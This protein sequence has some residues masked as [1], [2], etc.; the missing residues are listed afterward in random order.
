MLGSE[1]QQLVIRSLTA[2]S[3]SAWLLSIDVRS[4][5]SPSRTRNRTKLET[6]TSIVV[7]KKETENEA[8][9]K[10]SK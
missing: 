9:P 4:G 5:L 1:S 7:K 3:P 8:V 10:E 6:F 2:L